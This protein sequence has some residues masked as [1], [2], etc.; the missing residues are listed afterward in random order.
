MAA[1]TLTQ[2]TYRIWARIGN[3]LTSAVAITM[4]GVVVALA[5]TNVAAQLAQ[6][7]ADQLEHETP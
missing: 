3:P 1:V 7:A 6:L 5:G 4:Y 2:D